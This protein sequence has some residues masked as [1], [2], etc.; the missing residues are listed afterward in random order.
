MKTYLKVAYIIVS[1]V[2]LVYIAGNLHVEGP[3]DDLVNRLM[4]IR[5]IGFVALMLIFY[6]IFFNFLGKG[7]GDK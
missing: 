4:S 1:V 3:A 2:L 5:L 7:K 6:Y